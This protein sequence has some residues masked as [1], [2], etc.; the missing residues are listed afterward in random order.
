[1]KPESHK[2]LESL[3]ENVF[4]SSTGA[5]TEAERSVAYGRSVA[6]KHRLVAYI[7]RLEAWGPVEVAEPT[8]ESAVASSVRCPAVKTPLTCAEMDAKEAAQIYTMLKHVD[9]NARDPHHNAAGVLAERIAAR[10]NERAEAERRANALTPDEMVATHARLAETV[11]SGE[12]VV[13]ITFRAARTLCAAYIAAMRA[14]QPA[15][16]ISPP[17]PRLMLGG[18]SEMTHDYLDKEMEATLPGQ[19]QGIVELSLRAAHSLIVAH[20]NLEQRLAE[21][22]PRSD[23]RPPKADVAAAVARLCQDPNCPYCNAAPHPQGRIDHA[24]LQRVVDGWNQTAYPV[25]VMVH[26]IHDLLHEF[27]A[28]LR[29]N[30]VLRRKNEAL[31]HNC[32]DLDGSRSGLIERNDNQQREINRLNSQLHELRGNQTR[33][34]DEINSLRSKL[35]RKSPVEMTLDHIKE[36]AA[37][38]AGEKEFV[39]TAEVPR[40]VAVPALGSHEAMATWLT[41]DTEKLAVVSRGE[42]HA[43]MAEYR[44]KEEE[45]AR[46]V[47]DVHAR[48]DKVEA[49]LTEIQQA[50]MLEQPIMS[51]GEIAA[52]QHEFKAKCHRITALEAGQASAGRE[53]DEARDKITSMQTQLDSALK[54]LD[55]TLELAVALG[56]IA[57]R[58][59]ADL[60]ILANQDRSDLWT[61]TMEILV[62]ASLNKVL[63]NFRFL[64]PAELAQ[65]KDETAPE[66]IKFRNYYTCPV[67]DRQWTDDWSATCD[68]TCP[69]CGAENISPTHSK[70][71]DPATGQLVDLQTMPKPPQTVQIKVTP[72]PD[73][74]KEPHRPHPGA[75]TK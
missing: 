43:L 25:P 51:N 21:A 6:D 75:S 16:P 46:L 45:I 44:E 10:A 49:Q 38:A 11:G 24:W 15:Q 70:D 22:Q 14:I 63:R 2:L 56:N 36:A 62:E 50:R 13:Q 5:P 3:I 23:S 55:R 65:P 66:P 32:K 54:A 57:E 64:T 61:G 72:D 60:N 59:G 29:S 30:D 35:G 7:E 33:Q 41:I 17:F 19:F 4:V 67:C 40:T 12:G 53:L 18:L 52:F 42:I 37:I 20:Q 47:G 8:E 73:L 74:M 1:M 68:D 58:R 28:T 48:A 31:L 69:K 34:A 39:S 27:G 26:Q 9:E 71:L